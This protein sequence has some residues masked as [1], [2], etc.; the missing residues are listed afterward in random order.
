MARPIT[1]PTTSFQTESGNQPASQLDNNFSTLSGAINDSSNGWLNAN[2][3]TGSQN[4]YVVTLS[5]APSA[6]NQGFALVFI[7]ANTN[8]D[9]SVIN[10]NG[11]GSQSIF[12]ALGNALVGGDII[13]GVA[14]MLVY[15]SGAFRIVSPCASNLLGSGGI[16]G[17]FLNFGNQRLLYDDFTGGIGGANIGNAG[18]V[19]GSSGWIISASGNAAANF[20][21]TYADSVDKAFGVLQGNVGTGAANVIR[22]FTGPLISAQGACELDFRILLSQA[23]TSSDNYNFTCGLVDTNVS[24]TNTVRFLGQFSASA[25]VQ[26]QTVQGGSATNTTTLALSGGQFIRFRI[27]LSTAF[28]SVSFFING[29]QLGTTIN[30]GIPLNTALMPFVGIDK[31]SGTTNLGWNIDQFYLNYLYSS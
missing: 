29:T 31:T 4:N 26:G 15:V 3:D 9:G 10:V 12:N 24:Y 13:A 22:T 27:F 28:G 20:T 2:V 7:P 8:T 14:V 18:F 30:G 25:I 17:G 1:L 16:S 5:P 6:Y 19:P 21:G 23:P 11:I